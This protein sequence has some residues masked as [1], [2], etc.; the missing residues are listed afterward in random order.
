MIFWIVAG[1]MSVIVAAALVIPLLR[2]KAHSSDAND[3]DVEVYKDQIA[4]LDREHSAGRLTNDQ[5]AAARAEIA[6]RLLAADNRRK[7]SREHAS[8]DEADGVAPFILRSAR[9]RARPR[10]C[11]AAVLLLVAAVFIV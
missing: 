11:T 5:V 3:Y 7:L 10:A 2:A 1:L 4:E 6:R 8:R 9:I